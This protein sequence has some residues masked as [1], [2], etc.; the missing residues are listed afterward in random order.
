MRPD[1]ALAPEGTDLKQEELPPFPAHYPDD[2]P[3]RPWYFLFQGQTVTVGT[4]LLSRNA[5]G[6][7]A[8]GHWDVG[9]PQPVWVPDPPAPTGADDDRPPREMPVRD[10]LPNEQLY[11]GPLGIPGVQR[12]DL[13][14]SADEASGKFTPGDRAMLRLIYQAISEQAIKSSN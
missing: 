5:R 9:S 3:R 12:T 7:G 14:L 10:L 11:T 1:L 2:E 4:L 8:P 6:V 13:Q